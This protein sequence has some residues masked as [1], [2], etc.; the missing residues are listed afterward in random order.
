[1]AARLRDLQV[2]VFDP[3]L[4]SEETAERKLLYFYPPTTPREEQ[5][6]SVGIC[7]AITAFMSTFTPDA[8]ESVHTQKGRQLYLQPEPHLWL[9]LL[10][11]HPAPAAARG[12]ASAT[13]TLLA[14]ATSGSQSSR[15]NSS[16]APP[17]STSE[18]EQL[19]AA[20]EAADDGALQALLASVYATLRLACG[21][22]QA[23]AAARGAE[24]LRTL[25]E[26]VMPMVLKLVLTGAE[27]DLS[28][29]DLLDTLG[30]M[31]FLPLERRLYLRVQYAANLVLTR[32]ECVRHVLILHGEHL[33]W[34]SLTQAATS[35]LHAYLVAAVAS[36]PPHPARAER[37]QLN[38]A[39][40]PDEALALGIALVQVPSPRPRPRP[41]IADPETPRPPDPVPKP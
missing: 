8:V 41:R 13:S 12:A 28:R 34:S 20:E 29:P 39:A 5:V 27:D 3:R 16:A 25:L 15:R 14:A 31:K 21:P 9:A 40:L 22:L 36:P 38:T 18:C 10:V 35:A 19:P 37:L 4:G 32:H 23:V 17:E 7:E 26:L 24:E 6:K 1:M 2:T 30:G 33:V 11:S